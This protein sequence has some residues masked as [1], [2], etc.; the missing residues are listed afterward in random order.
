MKGFAGRLIDCKDYYCSISSE[1]KWLNSKKWAAGDLLF[2][3]RRQ[4]TVTEQSGSGLTDYQILIELDSTNF[5]FSHANEDGSDIR[6]HDG[7][8]LLNYWIEKWDSANQEAKIWVKVPSIPANSSTSF[9]M[10]YGNP[11][12]ASASNGEDTFEFFDDFEAGIIRDEWTEHMGDWDITTEPNGNHHPYVVNNSNTAPGNQMYINTIQHNGGYAIEGIVEAVSVKDSRLMC[13]YAPDSK[14]M[15][16]GRISP[17]LDEIQIYYYSGSD[18]EKLASTPH[19]YEG[20]ER[21]K[22]FVGID[23]NGNIKVKDL[24]NNIV[25]TATL[26][27]FSGYPGLSYP[28]LYTGGFWDDIFIRKYTDPEPSVSIGEEETP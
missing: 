24:I 2:D 16:M 4:I 11:N 22:L 7:N 27:P 14:K 1:A 9:Y 5:D 19:T 17:T 6:F 23:T 8:N 10:C 25:A 20:G 28:G 13:L 18:W 15:I 26:S 12:V 21:I 3:Y